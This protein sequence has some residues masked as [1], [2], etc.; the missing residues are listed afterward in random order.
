MIKA[1][2][3]GANGKMGKML[4]DCLSE[5]PLCTAVAGVDKFASRTISPIHIYPSLCDVKE[6]A[7]VIIDFSIKDTAKEILEYAVTKKIPVVIATT[8]YGPAEDALVAKASANIAIFKS[9]S[10][11]LG[12]YA[13]AEL[14]KTTAKLFGKDADIEIIEHHHNQKVDAPSGTALILADAIKSVRPE[15]KYV[16]GREGHTGARK[17]D[18]MGIMAIRGGTVVGKHEVLFMLN[19][20]VITLKHE[21][22]SRAMFANGAIKATQ[23]IVNQKPGIYSLKDMLAN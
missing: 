17:K 7:D 20:E 23:F 13:L 6:T 12:I 11:S 19:N 4:L 1:I 21:A 3:Y 10:M 9:G 14:A 18:E 2:I 16:Y 8:G 15:L 22:E 5:N